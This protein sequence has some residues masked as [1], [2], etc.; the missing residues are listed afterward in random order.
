[1]VGTNSQKLAIAGA[2]TLIAE[3]A[4]A[5]THTGGLGVIVG[6]AA[7]AVA[8]WVADEIEQATGKEA[9]LPATSDTSTT[10]D[11]TQAKEPGQPSL[12]YRMLNGK[13]VRSGGNND[14]ELQAAKPGELQPKGQAGPW[15]PPQFILDD[16]ISIVHDFNEQGYVYF[17][18]SEDGGIAIALNEMYHVMDVSSSGKGKSNRF[19]L[20]MMQMVGNCKT[21]YINPLA[22]NVKPVI[23]ER[24]I[25]V[26]KPIY[27]CLAN[28]RPIKEGT[29]IQELMTSLVE[30]IKQRN[31]LEDQ[32]DFS[33]QMEPIFV[34]I[35]ELPEVFA[36]CPDAL[37]LL[38]KIGRMGRQFCVFLWIASQTANVN[39]IGLSTAA[40]AQFK[41]RIY[42]GGDKISSDRMMKGSVPKD[43]ER[44]LQSNGAG[45]TLM[46]ADGMRACTFV[47][48]P[49]VTNEA[50]FNYL[51]LPPFRKEDWIKGKA[52]TRTPRQAP[53][54]PFTPSPNQ[55]K[56]PQ[57]EGESQGESVKGERRE[58]VKVPNE[59]DILTAIEALEEENRPLTLNAIAKLAGLTWRQYDDIEDVASCSGYELERGKG[60]PREA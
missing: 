39:D 59:E 56:T 46:L 15:I 7:G 54:H 32:G 50:L 13:S 10:P 4:L 53:F 57:T 23:D 11:A 24:E 47:R 42:G 3:P 30:E 38:D 9:S 5:L 21:Y 27:D 17:G 14:S 6:L 45:L 1:M 60:R 44:T 31:D 22:A 29:E 20:A 40:Q 25:E 51:G 19:R 36:R 33:W 52:T 55:P 41:T 34:F 18:N 37:K 48:S 16:V 35:D 58:R 26:W 2:A 49:L 12:L 28:K 43:T 8:Y